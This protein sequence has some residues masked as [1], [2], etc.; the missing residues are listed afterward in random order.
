MER[1]EPIADTD[2]PKVLP[3]IAEYRDMWRD[4][5][6]IFVF[7]AMGRYFDAPGSLLR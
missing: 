7:E 5:S 4:I 3:E 1:P 2:G 6:F